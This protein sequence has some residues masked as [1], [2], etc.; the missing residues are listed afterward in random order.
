MLALWLEVRLGKRNILELYLN[1]V[2]FG[3]GAYGVETAAQRFFGKSAREVTLV[4][5]AVLAGLLKAPSKYSPASN[6]A[7]GAGARR[8]V[9]AKMVEAGLL[10]GGGG[11]TRPAARRIALRRQP[12]QRGQSGVDYAVDAVLERLPSLAG[13]AGE[14]ARRRDDHRRR[15]AAPR[16]G[17]G[18]RAL[19]DRRGTD[20]QCQPGR[21]RAA[22]TWRAASAR[23]SAGAR[24]RR[25]SSIAR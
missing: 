25:A 1:R 3:A 19:I 21:P 15:P 5:A 12:L 2:Y 14:R 4:E 9:L 18:A 10:L 16:P 13:L 6:P 20:R 22:S 24:T 8:S 23:W 17:A 11:A 7:A